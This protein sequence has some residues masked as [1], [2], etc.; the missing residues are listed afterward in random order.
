MKKKIIVSGPLLSRSGYGDM[1]RFALKALMSQE[2]NY[3]IYVNVTNW[4]NT[5]NIIG[6]TQEIEDIYKL[7][8][9]TQLEGQKNGGQIVLDISL[10]ITIPN[11]WKKL[12]AYNIGYTAGIETNMISPAWYEPAMQ[13]D[14][15]I[16]ISEHAKASFENTVFGDNAGKRFKVTTPIEVCHFPEKKV[17]FKIPELELKHDFNYL[18]VAQWGPRK[19]VE[20]A[21]VEFMNEFKD[22]NVGLVLKVNILNDSTIDR[23]KVYE[24]IENLVARF[25]N[26]KCS[27]HVLHGCLSEEEMQGLYR[28]PKIK[29]ILST[30]HGEGFGFPL[31]DATFA[32]LPVI[33]TDWSGHLDFLKVPQED[34]KDKKL[35][36]KIDFELKPIQQE[37]VWQGVLEANTQWAYPSP[38]SVKSRMREVLQDYSRFKSWSKKLAAYNREIFTEEKIFSKFLNAFKRN[39]ESAIIL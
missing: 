3:D 13:M 5:G 28:H 22:E 38:S 27:I 23:N 32:E 31:F 16:V 24:R 7:I 35:F 11:E 17:D 26:K 29:A 36:A 8:E 37:H 25:T 19:N 33:A 39:N 20:Q 9:K 15:I 18:L 10:Q 4:G 21:I 30:T 12:A 14:K 6:K 2:D 34:G 1:A